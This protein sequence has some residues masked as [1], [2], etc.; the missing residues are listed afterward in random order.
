MSLTL[1]VNSNNVVNNGLNSD[2]NYQFINGGF[3]IPE[4]SQLC[5]SQVTIPYSWFNVNTSLYNNSQF[6]YT[7]PTA[8]GQQT[9]T[10]NLPNGFY[11]AS[12]L[13]TYLQ[14]IFVQNGQYLVD[15]N[16]ENVYYM[17][18]ADDVTYYAVQVICY[19]VP[20]SLPSGWTNPTN[21]AFPPTPTTPQLVILSNNFGN[22]IGFLPGSY[23]TSPAS[24]NVDFLSNTVVNASPVNSLVLRCNLIDNNVVMPSDILDGVPIVSVAFG[25]NINYQP[26]FA[27]WIKLKAGKYAGFRLSFVDQ[28]LN[29][30]QARDPNI[31]ICLLIKFPD[32]NTQ[33][34]KF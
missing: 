5:V 24:A 8:S 19:T 6:Q 1:I 31:L 32:S 16:G 15:Q 17:S 7:F 18:I 10:V 9:F 2:Y 20:T 3:Q 27:R 12:N 14:Q 34:K 29:L 11:D 25:S 28:N 4:G 30:V 23:P 13:N 22:L 33:N 26:T 21:M